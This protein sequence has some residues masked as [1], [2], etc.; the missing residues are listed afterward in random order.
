[1]RHPHCALW[2]GTLL[3]ALTLAGPLPAKP[4]GGIIAL[5]RY[6]AANPQAVQDQA[7][8]WLKSTGRADARALQ[9][10]QAIWSHQEHATLD[11]L[12]ATFAL[13][14][15]AAARLLAEA[16]EFWAPPPREIPRA[17]SDARLPVFYRA[18]LALAYARELSRRRIYE[19][20]QA[21]LAQVKPDDVVDPAAYFYHKAIAEFALVRKADAER[22]I[23]SLLDDVA[24]PPERC[25]KICA[26]MSAEMKTWNDA[27]LGQVARLMK[28]IGRR[29][30]L[31]QGG[32][33]T[34]HQQGEVIALLDNLIK[35]RDRIVDPP[36]DP[37]D[38]RPPR[39]PGDPRRPKPGDVDDGNSGNQSH[40]HMEDSRPGNNGGNGIVGNKPA[41][42][43]DE[44]WGKLN[45]KERARAMAQAYEEL[46]AEYRQIIE[47]LYQLEASRAANK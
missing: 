30:R 21:I 38:P 3:S 24:D 16:G 2:L 45:E 43:T 12:T 4:A 33:Q 37:R 25:V 14:D 32:P 40:R 9:A 29:L 10:F 27:D 42:Y 26:L 6:Q 39:E 13:G 47:A 22:S 5:N 41:R 46:P 8:A 1:M 36:P 31:V 34:Q 20:S 28:N 18:N 23:A 44:V 35:E 19:Q 7:L 11:R 15:A 17:F